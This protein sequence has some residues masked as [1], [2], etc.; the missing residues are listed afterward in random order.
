[1]VD[2]AGNFVLDGDFAVEVF[3]ATRSSLRRMAFV[4]Y[5]VFDLVFVEEQLVTIGGIAMRQMVP[6]ALLRCRFCRCFHFERV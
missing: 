3:T 4:D 5:A 6:Q 1:M 2:F